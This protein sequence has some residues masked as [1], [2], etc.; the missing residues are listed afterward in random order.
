MAHIDSPHLH[1]SSLLTRP[2]DEVKRRI[3]L[4]LS[5]PQG[6][7]LNDNV[8]KARFYNR[9]FSLKLVSVD[10]IVQESLAFNNPLIFK[11]DVSRAFRN[12]R[13][14][15]V[16]ILKLCIIWHGSLYLDCVW[17]DAQGVIIPGGSRSQCPCYE[18]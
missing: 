14:D 3:I 5:H 6:R 18:Q 2:K 4:N 8:D 12:L 10:D 7:S 17:L 15:P 16:D 1:C 11:I 9:H 13:V